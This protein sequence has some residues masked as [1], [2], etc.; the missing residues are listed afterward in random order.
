MRCPLIPVYSPQRGWECPWRDLI[1]ACLI[2]PYYFIVAPGA[3]INRISLSHFTIYQFTPVYMNI[4]DL[5][6][7]IFESSIRPFVGFVF[8]SSSITHR[9]DA[10][11]LNLQSFHIQLLPY[12]PLSQ[13]KVQDQRALETAESFRQLRLTRNS[14]MLHHS[15]RCCPNSA[16]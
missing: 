10:S 15:G 5:Y 9:Q 7:F 12:L 11:L 14:L 6:V 4:I 13:C 8:D 3:I 1:N 16:I 2:L